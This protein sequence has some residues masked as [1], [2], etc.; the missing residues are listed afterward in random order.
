MLKSPYHLHLDYAFVCLRLIK[1]LKHHWSR[2]INKIHH[3]ELW[4]WLMT[5]FCH[6]NSTVND[7]LPPTTAALWKSLQRW[8]DACL[9]N[10]GRPVT[11]WRYT[12]SANQFQSVN[13]NYASK[14]FHTWNFSTKPRN[15][16]APWPSTRFRTVNVTKY[17]R[18][19]QKYK[20]SQIRNTS[21]DY[22]THQVHKAKHIVLV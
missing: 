21:K 15:T 14:Q 5:L 16:N 2:M 18:T 11:K 20:M 9:I 22:H 12:Q 8:G 4:S 19:F 6:I 3:S 1:M 7:S 13:E 17:K 10:G